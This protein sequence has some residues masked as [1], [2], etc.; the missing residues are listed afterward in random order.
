[1]FAKT[2]N[3]IKGFTQKRTYSYNFGKIWLLI[4]VKTAHI[5]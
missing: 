2:A 5:I 1:M 3:K 4:Y